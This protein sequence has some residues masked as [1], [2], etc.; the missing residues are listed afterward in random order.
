MGVTAFLKDLDEEIIGILVIHVELRRRRPLQLG[1]FPFKRSRHQARFAVRWNDQSV[2]FGEPARK[3]RRAKAATIED[4]L[5][6]REDHRIKPRSLH[7]GSNP[8]EAAFK[9][10]GG[11]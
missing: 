6:A 9:L 2:Q 11:K 7:L 4:V 1:D 5:A 8:D 10:A 3:V